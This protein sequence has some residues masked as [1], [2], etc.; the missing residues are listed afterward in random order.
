MLGRRSLSYQDWLDIIRR[1]LWILLICIVLCPVLAYLGS[2]LIPNRYTSQTVVLIEQQRVP[3]AFVKPVVT[4]E[5]VARLANLQEQILSRSHLEPMIE[6]FGLYRKDVGKPPVDDLVE[7]MRKN[8]R[9][10]PIQDKGQVGGMTGFS[11]SFTADNPRLAQQI[12][13]EITSMFI[14]E[15]LRARERR[16]AGTTDFISKQLEEA[17][18]KLDQQ[19]AE[20][21][22]FKMAHVGELPGQEQ[23]TLN[24]LAAYTTQLETVNQSISRLQQEK[25]YVQSLLTQQ[26][27]AWEA[28][29]QTTDPQSMEQQL[30]L[31]Q[32][33]V[34]KLE[35]RYRPD[36]PDLIKA[37]ADAAN[38]KR[39]VEAARNAEPETKVNYRRNSEPPE[40][41]KLRAQ[42]K[43]YELAVQ[44]RAEEQKRL[45]ATTQQLQGRL[46]LSPAVEEQ[47]KNLTRDYQSALSFYNELLG[48]RSQ[49]SMATDLERREQGEQFRV[50]DPANL[51][52]RPTS[53]NRPVI[54]LVGLLFG[55][56]LGIGL[57]VV[58][59]LSQQVVRSEAD[60]HNVLHLT[61]LAVI[62][63]LD[64]RAG[65][66]R[67]SASSSPGVQHV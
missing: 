48:K 51:P 33:E 25:T 27:G 55:A 39:K 59:E 17:K 46:Q 54:V 63:S 4:Q 61:T 64:K 2:R 28:S 8:L 11:V 10:E 35:V 31:A 6:K 34:S 1:R 49:A 66:H 21:A 43:E 3:D 57:T 7:L 16:A 52:L 62:P 53:P 9:V 41:Q 26:L 23:T 38:L 40:I 14:E 45:Q 60:V 5:L 50:M 13:S 12:C 44:E 36:H 32:A 15:N 56:G 65:G 42:M 37:R 30:I 47:Y 20:L 22:R 29:L 24:L 58:M 18:Q 67:E 19:D